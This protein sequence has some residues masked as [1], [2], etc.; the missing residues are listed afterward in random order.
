MSKRKGRAEFAA[1]ARRTF[2]KMCGLKRSFGSQEAAEE[3]QVSFWRE[4]GV[5]AKAHA[6]R[7]PHCQMWHNAS[8][9]APDETLPAWCR[10]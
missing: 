10:E 1:V 6:Y 8:G 2:G 9:K 7:C 5:I 3:F 4:R